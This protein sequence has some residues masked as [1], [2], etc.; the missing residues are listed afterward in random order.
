MLTK[1]ATA[2]GS[3]RPGRRGEAVAKWV[4]DRAK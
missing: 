1:I 4:L 2:L 3:A